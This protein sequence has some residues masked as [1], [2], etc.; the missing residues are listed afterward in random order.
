MAN[1]Q[2][3]DVPEQYREIADASRWR[4]PPGCPHCERSAR[5]YYLGD[6][7]ETEN[8]AFMT[9]WVCSAC[10]M[11]ITLYTKGKGGG[12]VDEKPDLDCLGGVDSPQS[13]GSTQSTL[14]TESV[15]FE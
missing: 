1:D 8:H 15:S 3:R 6:V 12:F 7:G 4:I 13:D 5:A 2:P 14:R 10:E 11:P 9:G